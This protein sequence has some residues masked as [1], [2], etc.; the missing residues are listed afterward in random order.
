METEAQ[1]KFDLCKHKPEEMLEVFDGCPCR[2][3]KKLVHQ[4]IK[5]SIIDLSPQNCA[6][7]SLFESKQT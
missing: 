7:C 4:C 2:K 1:K 5:L 6:G 3:K